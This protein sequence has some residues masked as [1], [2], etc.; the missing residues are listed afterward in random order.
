MDTYQ[1]PYIAFPGI[2]PE[3]MGF[4]QQ[5][6][7]DL[8][9]EQKK[10]FYMVYSSKRKNPQDLLLF[11]LLGFVVVAGVQRFVIGQIGMG[12]LY[13]FT[14]GFCLIGTIVDL[15]NHKT[16]ANDFNRQMAYESYQMAKMRS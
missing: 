9:E 8:N 1:N 10:Y 12:L 15:I 6:T 4:L 11:T 7:A 3:E 16:L 5:G 14:G 2:T 13:L